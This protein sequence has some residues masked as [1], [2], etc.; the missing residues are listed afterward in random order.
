MTERISIKTNPEAPMF[1]IAFR[2]INVVKHETGGNTIIEISVA[3]LEKWSEQFKDKTHVFR[4]ESIKQSCVKYQGI[5][6]VEDPNLKPYE[7]AIKYHH[8]VDKIPRVLIATHCEAEWEESLRDYQNRQQ[9]ARRLEQHEWSLRQRRRETEDKK[10]IKSGRIK[11][12]DAMLDAWWAYG[13]DPSEETRD[14]FLTAFGLAHSALET[15]CEREAK[16]KP[17]KQNKTTPTY[18][19]DQLEDIIKSTMSYTLA[20]LKHQKENPQ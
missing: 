11:K 5:A 20:E 8:P 16:P 17:K 7:V 1:E 10:R 4:Y 14:N 3:S 18:T 12:F 19:A 15:L 9:K 6:V 13:Q 2:A